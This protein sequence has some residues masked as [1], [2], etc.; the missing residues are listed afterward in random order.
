MAEPNALKKKFDEIF[1]AQ[2]WT[3]GVD[4]IKMARKR[5]GLE[6][7]A[8]VLELGQQEQD[9][10]KAIANSKSIREL[11]A[12]IEKLTL[13]EKVLQEE[14]TVAEK[15]AREKR[16]EANQFLSIINELAN[17]Q[18]QFDI[19][20]DTVTELRDSIDMLPESDEGLKRAVDQYESTLAG[21]EGRIQEDTTQYR[22]L[23]DKV[24]E[25]RTKLNDS[26]SEKGR[27]ESD[28]EKYERQL[29]A[30]TEMIQLAA[31]KHGLRGFTNVLD[32]DQIYAF[33]EKIQGV[34]SGKKKE[35][36]R[37][38]NE[39]ARAAD[40]AGARISEMEGKKSTMASERQFSKAKR[41][42]NDRKI[43]RLQTEAD[44]VDYDE[45]H[46]NILEKRRAALEERFHQAQNGLHNS[47]WDEKIQGAKDELSVLEKTGEELNS[48][49]VN[50]TRL[51]SER[52]QLDLRRKE[53]KEREGNLESLVGTY[54]GRLSSLMNRD[55]DIESLAYDYKTVHTEQLS[56]VREAKARCD[57]LQKELDL[58][59]FELTEAR[60]RQAAALDTKTKYE[61][62]ILKVLKE[63]SETPDTVTIND[64]DAELESLEDAKAEADKNLNLFDEMKNYYNIAQTYLN[65]NNKCKL[66]QRGFTDEQSKAK[67]EAQIRKGL[68][69][70]QKKAMEKEV[71]V[72]EQQLTKVM[73]V[74]PDHDALV[75]LKSELSKMKKEVEGAQEKR[76]EKLRQVEAAEE[77]H[78]Q[79]AEV[80]TEFESVSKNVSD[81]SQ[82]HADI[83]EARGQIA[84]L[85]SQ[86]QLSGTGRS[87][88]EIQNAQSANSEKL[89]EVKK[90]LEHMIRER[91]R[92]LDLISNLEL[93]RS[94]NKNK[95]GHAKHQMEL[96]S[97][98]VRDIQGLK[99]DSQRQDETLTNIDQELK[100]LQ[101]R[102]DA[103]RS[104]R[105]A[106]RERGREKARLVAEDRDAV[107]QT[108]SN[109]KIIED[110]IQDYVDRGKP[111]TLA[112]TERAIQALKENHE[113]LKTQMNDI[114]TRINSQ[115]QELAQ[116]DR[117]RKNINDNIRYRENC[118][119]LDTLSKQIKELQTHNARE[120]YDNL[121]REAKHYTDELNIVTNRISKIR[122]TTGA[123]DESLKTL[124]ATH[125]TFYVGVEEKYKRSKIAVEATKCAIDDLA[126]FGNVMSQAIME[127]HSLKMEEVNRIVGELW[128]ATYQG[129]DID[130][131][132]IRSENETLPANGK[133]DRRTYNYRVTMV[134]QD[135]EMD[136]RG[137]CSAGQKVLASIIIRL[138]LAE[139]FGVNCGLIAL[140]EPTTNLDSDNIRSLAVSLHGIIKA[141]QAQANF[142]LIVITHDEEFLRHMRCNEFTDKFYRVKRDI[143]Q[144]SVISKEDISRITD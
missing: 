140:D 1:D 121:M 22:Q 103:A 126:T 34:L 68:S 128:R 9:K 83:Q 50:C 64:F 31:T 19:R 5:Q 44:S 78:S 124:L 14:V 36:D 57:V 38:Q 7:R 138:A 139:S 58:R 100:A 129:T 119:T 111:A 118:R 35:H 4:A 137:R 24:S 92:N 51:S 81:I 109:L 32:D 71:R 46:V 53:T 134:K 21:L 25:V 127:F 17:L 3:K 144:C 47:G 120:D 26:L 114:M 63:V 73:A 60:K 27:L 6:L 116:A 77:K 59:D 54:S 67:I 79:V 110:E 18:T 28:K 75:R 88:D 13:Q 33:N 23:E 29:E 86:S 143:N 84:R 130:T 96:K 102:I 87:A 61:Q 113:L 74:R 40:E 98:L 80:L 97:A 69:D 12:E 37:L 107:A 133:T 41:A 10:K 52:A 11:E 101:P 48:E 117:R 39:L 8:K 85:Q 131:I 115:K 65:T 95:L 82:L 20:Q 15:K 135:T 112:S 16:E 90:S 55:F 108:I 42:E 106:E 123:K 56:V 62:S 104:Q 141:R 76:E 70:E 43:K 122:G 72:V 49:L 45:G 2:K 66:C 105:D 94:D 91:Q 99:E 89:R 132:I 142:Q 136:M 93:E 125:E 30:R